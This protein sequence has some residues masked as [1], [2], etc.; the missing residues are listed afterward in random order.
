MG[1]EAEGG[2]KPWQEV[3][4][5]PGRA[6]GGGEERKGLEWPRSDIGVQTMEIW[7]PSYPLDSSY[8]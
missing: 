8:P 7:G 5:G 1:G 3:R 4:S 6:W 2:W